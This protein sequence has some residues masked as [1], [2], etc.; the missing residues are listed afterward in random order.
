MSPAKGFD[1]VT[2]DAR[3]EVVSST[4]TGTLNSTFPTPLQS[5]GV[6]TIVTFSK[7]TDN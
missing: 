7:G 2:V 5:A 1:N 4:E 3:R 6:S